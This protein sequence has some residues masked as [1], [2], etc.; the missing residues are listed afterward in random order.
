MNLPAR[1]VKYIVQSD[2]NTGMLLQDS[3]S[4][5]RTNNTAR[6]ESEQGMMKRDTLLYYCCYE[7]LHCS[8]MTSDFNELNNHM[9][10]F[11]HNSLKCGK[12]LNHLT[13][14]HGDR[15]HIEEVRHYKP[16]GVFVK[17]VRILA[18]A[19]LCEKEVEIL[20]SHQE[21]IYNALM[22]LDLYGRLLNR[23]Q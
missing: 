7:C 1:A 11:H 10:A 5:Q 12:E 20:T 15:S 14:G 17:L 18:P 6:Y 9:Y 8:F 16:G 23:N 21:T 4:S 3:Q 22:G 2:G 13:E 19:T